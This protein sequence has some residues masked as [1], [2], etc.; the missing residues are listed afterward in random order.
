MRNI[1]AAFR[2]LTGVQAPSSAMAEPIISH[3]AERSVLQ[4]PKAASLEPY[5]IAGRKRLATCSG[6]A[7]FRGYHLAV[8]N[9]YGNHLR[10]Y[11]FHPGAEVGD[12]PPR[13]ELLHEM[14][15]G[16]SYPEDVAVSPDGRLLAIAHSLSNDFGISLHAIDAVSL[17]PATGEMIRRGRAF[18]SVNFSPDSQY[19]AF[20]EVATPGYV[21]IMRVASPSR[22]RT[23]LLQSRD[24]PLMPKAVAFSRDGRF[25][26]IGKSQMLQAFSLANGTG[27][28]LAGLLLIRRTA[29]SPNAPSPSCGAPTFHWEI[30][31][32]ARSCHRSP[33]GAI[34]SCSAINMPM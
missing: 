27:A 30:S 4:D 28:E 19:L 25:V 29:S 12:R 33:A 10:V 22:E 5:V 34:A 11:R 15:E 1:V 14:T 32:P 6:V 18:H 2:R 16:L 23:C 26:A 9:L 7:W 20:A 13:L 24:A 8:V 17:A 31:R 21:E 3:G